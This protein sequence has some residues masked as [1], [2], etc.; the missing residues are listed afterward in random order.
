MKLMYFLKRRFVT[1]RLKAEAFFYKRAE[2]NKRPY[3]VTYVGD[4]PN[5]I[6]PRVLYLLGKPKKEWLAGMICP[7]GCGDLIE[8]VLDGYSPKWT[9]S[10]SHDGKPTLSPSIYRSIKCRSHFF[11]E[12]GKIKW[13]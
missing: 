5:K 10:L 7:C 3:V 13:C 2:R 6:L 1:F 4:F 12:H 9:L 11:L 8:L